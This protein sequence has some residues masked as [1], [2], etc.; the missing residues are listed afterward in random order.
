MHVLLVPGGG[1]SVHGYFPDLGRSLGAGIGL[2]ECDAP[3]RDPARGR[4]WLPLPEHARWLADAARREASGP[5]VV[6]GH[7]LG[8]L[9]A[10]R[11]ALDEPELVAG[12]LL[13]DPSP[14]VLAA[15]LPRPL[16]RL[17]G[18]G[19]RVGAHLRRML[20]P[21]PRRRRAPAARSVPFRV[22]IRWFFLL[23]GLALA[24]DV[25]AGGAAGIP[26][27]LVSASEH[28]PG[29]P[30]R[31]AHERLTSWL[32]GALFEVWPD[33][34]HPLHLE[35]PDRVADATLALLERS[36]GAPPSA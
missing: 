32:P 24:A 22:R 23:G 28:G 4:R 7:S 16:L 25:A 36:A 35:Q 30:I 6:V 19:R 18:G 27:V 20:P 33:T 34:T 11:L 1:S 12:L 14:P 15:L 29:T 5:V 31:R 13:L 26:T 21:T 9:I 10:L 8:G 17:I 3:G 2:I